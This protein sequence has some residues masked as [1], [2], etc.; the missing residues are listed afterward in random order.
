MPLNGSTAPSCNRMAGRFVV[1][2]WV[3][4]NK[5]NLDNEKVDVLGFSSSVDVDGW[6][7][8]SGHGADPVRG[9][10]CRGVPL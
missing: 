6:N 4:P 1:S 3:F 9:W 2:L 10:V 7:V 5:K 8:N